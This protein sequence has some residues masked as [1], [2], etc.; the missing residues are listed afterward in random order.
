M[1]GKI[2]S[3]EENIVIVDLKIDLDKEDNILSHHVTMVDGK[4]NIIG[5]IIDVKNNQAYINLLGEIVNDEFVFGVIRKP[6]FKSKV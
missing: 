3:V 2:V 6:S 4:R 1:I 5:E